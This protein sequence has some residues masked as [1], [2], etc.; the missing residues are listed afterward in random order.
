MRISDWSSDVCSSDLGVLGCDNGTA[1]VEAVHGSARRFPIPPDDDRRLVQPVLEA[2]GDDPD[3]A[4]VPV[5]AVGDDD[6]VGCAFLVRLL[7]RF[8]ADGSLDGTAFAVALFEDLREFG[9]LILIVS[10]QEL[11]S[12]SRVADAPARLAAGPVDEAAGARRAPGFR[13]GP[14]QRPHSTDDR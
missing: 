11:G 8:V 14:G 5:F 4:G 2:S 13:P 12:E 6:P 1:D 3:D 7:D 9:C 10:D